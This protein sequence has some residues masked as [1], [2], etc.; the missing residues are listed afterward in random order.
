MLRWLG[1][2]EGNVWLKDG[3]HVSIGEEKTRTGRETRG[4]RCEILHVVRI[5]VCLCRGVSTEVV[6]SFGPCLFSG[7][8]RNG[9][10][11]GREKS[12]VPRGRVDADPVTITDS[13]GGNQIKS[14]KVLEPETK[15]R[16]FLEKDELEKIVLM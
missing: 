13:E 16:Y 8:R 3:L 9:D 14:Q 2:T 5:R 12:M 1:W 10:G 4:P 6:R 11:G 15:C 7:E